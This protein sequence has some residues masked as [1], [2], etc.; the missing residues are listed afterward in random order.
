MARKKATSRKQ[1]RRPRVRVRPSAGL[2]RP[3][4]DYA[5]LLVDPC[6]ANLAHP[7]YQGATGGYLARFENDQIVNSSATDLGSM[8]MFCPGNIHD[9]AL[10]G[11]HLGAA[12]VT[13][14][15]VSMN[16][17]AFNASQPGWAFLKANSESARC[18]AA[19]VQIS[20]PGAELTRSGIV[21]LGQAN[22]S[23]LVATPKTTGQLRSMAQHVRR[24]PDGMVEI[25]LVPNV[26]SQNYTNAADT[27]NDTIEEDMPALFWS[28]WGIPA[29]TGVRVRTVAIYEWLPKNATG[30]N[31]PS[32]TTISAS[33]H[34]LND[35]LRYL[36]RTGDWATSGF[37]EASRAVSS[38]ASAA[39][40]GAN[41]VRG[42]LRIGAALMA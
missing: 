36:Q 28:V 8:G 10:G 16:L 30:I 15:T 3:A 11:Y 41:L 19:C 9:G 25:R 34:S 14:D 33:G 12:P 21:A 42:T 35:V 31:L 2:D 23:S 40:N 37:H 26:T 39:Y 5:Q 38:I 1:P 13:G 22:Y 17:N 4:L 27:S 24:M 6:G 7:V 32:A 29:S 20:Y 18:V